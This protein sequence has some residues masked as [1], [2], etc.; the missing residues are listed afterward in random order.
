MRSHENIIEDLKEELQVVYNEVL[1]LAPQAFQ[2]KLSLCSF[3]ATKQEYILKKKELIDFILQKVEIC[4]E[5]NDYQ[6]SPRGYC[7]L[8]YRGADNAYDEGFIISEGLIRHL[9]GSHGARQC[10]IIKALDKIA[11]YYINLQ[12]AKNA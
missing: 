9:K 5:P 7:P 12:K 11:Q 8:C 2:E 3:N 10:T 4:Q 6:V 1:E